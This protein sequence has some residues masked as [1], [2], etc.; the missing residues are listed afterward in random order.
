MKRIVSISI[1][2]VFVLSAST[3]PLAQERMEKR[4]T[5][6]EFEKKVLTSIKNRN[7]KLVHLFNKD[8]YEKMAAE[9]TLYSKITTHEGEEIPAKDS[10]EYWRYIG[11]ELGGTDLHFKLKSFYGWEL[12]L[13][14]APHPEETD[15]VIFEITKFSF[16]VGSGGQE[17]PDG[18]VG[19]A[20]RHKVRCIAD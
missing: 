10:G 14:D 7:E 12:M 6:K 8:E 19:S 16:T 4:M 13:S 15:F 9:F 20:Q 18:E 3:I 1:C 2:V 17:D 11:K 5:F